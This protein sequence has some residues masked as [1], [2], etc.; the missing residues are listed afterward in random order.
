MHVRGCLN[1]KFP[2]QEKN[3]ITRLTTF[4]VLSTYVGSSLIVLTAKLKTGPLTPII[5][6]TICY[7]FAREVL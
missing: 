6:E 2:L 5:H 1:E 7:H 3:F 4:I